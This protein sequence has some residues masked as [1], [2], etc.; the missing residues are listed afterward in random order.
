[1]RNASIKATVLLIVVIIHLLSF[2]KR[3]DI[4]V[5]QIYLDEINRNGKFFYVSYYG[6]L[7]VLTFLIDTN[8]AYYKFVVLFCQEICLYIMVSKL[9]GMNMVEWGKWEHI[10]FWL[11]S[12]TAIYIS[13]FSNKIKS[14][15][16]LKLKEYV[17]C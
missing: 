2:I 4:E 8:T 5:P 17:G 12:L 3:G 9:T 10:G 6:V 11:T 13:F 15:L 1:M 14:L 16:L 7:W